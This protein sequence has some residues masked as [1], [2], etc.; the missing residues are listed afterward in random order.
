[1]PADFDEGWTQLGH[2][3]QYCLVDDQEGN[4]IG[5][6]ERHGCSDLGGKSYGGSVPFNNPAGLA[7]WPANYPKWTVESLWPLTLSPSLLCRD[8]GHHGYIRQGVWVP[9]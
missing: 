1:M 5:I 4:C 6:I 2:G 7:A 3:V 9:V 8:C